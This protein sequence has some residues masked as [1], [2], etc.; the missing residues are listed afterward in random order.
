MDGHHLDRITVR[1]PVD[2]NELVLDLALNKDLI[3]D[4]FFERYQE[5]VGCFSWINLY[6][7]TSV[8]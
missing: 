1:L 8:N 6:I 7:D 3:P 4:T 5:Q 2:G